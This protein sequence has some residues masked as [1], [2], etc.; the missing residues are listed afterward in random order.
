M[1]SSPGNENAPMAS[2]QGTPEAEHMAHLEPLSPAV[3][4][5][6]PIPITP[7]ML[8][9][10]LDRKYGDF[11]CYDCNSGMNNFHLD[12][13]CGN[14]D[15]PDGPVSMKENPAILDTAEGATIDTAKGMAKSAAKGKDEEDDSA[16]MDWSK[17]TCTGLHL[18]GGGAPIESTFHVEIQVKR[19]SGADKELLK[20]C[21]V[22]PA[23]VFAGLAGLSSQI[24]PFKVKH[25][26][27]SLFYFPFL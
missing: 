21:G 9:D 17:A 24:K 11:G 4:H 22:N 6:K 25:T 8:L 10:E 18:N 14:P 1:A 13:V 26:I 5:T 27:L 15:D 20:A 7:N 2:D 16:K 12:W 23:T 19:I 3:F